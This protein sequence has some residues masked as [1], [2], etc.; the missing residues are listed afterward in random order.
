MAQHWEA[1]TTYA[2]KRKHER[3]SVDI[4]VYWGRTYECPEQGRVLSLSVG[5]CFL[6]TEKL[7]PV[8]GEVFINLWLPD[9]RPLAGEVRYRIEGYGVG[10]EFRAVGPLTAGQLAGIIEFYSKAAGA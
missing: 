7:L 9:G 5:G 6:R 1:M 2:E 8:G 3:V 10:V 4:Q